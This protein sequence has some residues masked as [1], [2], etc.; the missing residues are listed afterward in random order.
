MVKVFPGLEHRGW[1]RQNIAVL[2][3]SACEIMYYNR[4]F[5]AYRLFKAA[6][7]KDTYSIRTR[8]LFSAT[9]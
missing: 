8:E 4:K 6:S 3:L 5:F 1:S 2:K 7:V 9:E